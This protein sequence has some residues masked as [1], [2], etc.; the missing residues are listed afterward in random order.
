MKT[1]KL[2]HFLII[3]IINL[4][5]VTGIAQENINRIF[6]ASSIKIAE[7]RT[8]TIRSDF[9]PSVVGDT[10]Y[11]TS[12]SDE[13]LGKPDLKLRNSAFY[14]L[15]RA[16]IDEHGNTL[17]EREP[18]SEFLTK[19]HDGPV[20]YCKATRELFL[21]QS[22]NASVS[23]LPK[24]YK[25]DT[26]RLRIIIA[27]QINGK[28][29]SVINFPYNNPK[30]SVG[31]PAISLTGDTL[32]FSSDQPGGYGQTD[33]Y[34]SVKEAGLWSTPVNMGPQIN[35]SGK[36]EFS[37][38]AHNHTGRCFLI[39]ASTG[40]PGFGGL[41]LYYTQFPYYNNEIE[42]LGAPINT[43]DDDFDMVVPDDAEFGYLASNR[44]G[45]G[46]DDIY[47]FTFKK[48]IEP[49]VVIPPPEP[50]SP[51]KEL[52]VYNTRTRQPIANAKILTI[53]TSTYKTD[54]GG[55]A[56]LLN[57]N[58]DEYEV[59]AQKFGFNPA[60]K[61]LMAKVVAK[62]DINRDT[63]WMDPIVGKI[64]LLNIYYDYDKSD[65]L[66]ESA[67]ELDRLI[68]FMNENPDFKVQLSSHTDSRGNDT[69]NLRLSEQR[70][71]SAVQ[72]IVLHGIKADRITGKGYGETKLLNKCANGVECTPPEHRQ[73]RRT[74]IFIPEIGKSNDVKQ[75]E[76]DH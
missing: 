30:Y 3:L 7:V 65:I 22:D 11:F 57:N 25:K 43:P 42:H 37:F 49:V 68:A 36:E 58:K 31:H 14:D 18:V 71:Q 9:G 1:G 51:V 70:A 52:Y 15:F 55:K 4:I 47:K 6:D 41:D 66:P 63:L 48:F 60:K 53:D 28:W 24:F 20:S 72:Y 39:F 69:Y 21:T 16:K 33:L 8:N 67:V 32:V 23:V 50:L 54:P 56:A 44:P 76:G 2:F 38:I 75:T 64:T 45:T 46:S 74:E 59:V 26:I 61:F 13:V 73:N 12:Y 19:Y 62:G 10:L 40:R 35:T 27:K 17:T 5:S 29:T 34:Y